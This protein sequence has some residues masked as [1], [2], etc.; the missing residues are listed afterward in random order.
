MKKILLLGSFLVGLVLCQAQ[1]E[2]PQ[3]SVSGTKSMFE[4]GLHA[5]VPFVGGEV[6]PQFGYGGG[7]HIRLPLDHMFAIRLEGLYAMAKGD[8]MNPNRQFDNTWLSGALFGVLTLNNMRFDRPIRKTNIY[9][10]GGAGY[11][12]MEVVYTRNDEPRTPSPRTLKTNNPFVA[13][14]AGIAFR[15]SKRMN[16]G[17]EHQTGFV[18]GANADALDGIVRTGGE[19][20]AFGDSFNYTNLRINFNIGGDSKSEPLYWVNPFEIALADIS[21][22]ANNR[23][24]LAISDSDGDGVIDVLDQEPD[25]GPDAIVD[26]KGRTLDSDRDGVPD[27]QDMEPYYTPRPGERI[28]NQ[29]VVE[30]PIV[31][32]GV[33]ED[34][35]RELIDEAMNRFQAPTTNANAQTSGGGVTMTDLFLPMVHFGSG[36]DVIKYSDYGTLASVARVIKGSPDLRIAI[37]G[38]TDQTGDE[39]TNNELSYNRALAVIDHLVNNHGIARGR[40]VL[41]WKGQGE[42]LVPSTASYMN[43]RVEFRVASP[44]DVEQDPPSFDFNSNGNG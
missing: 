20:T 44:E 8:Q 10:L 33:T 34:R 30:N 37:I 9:V 2:K 23:A 13:F 16:V 17:I 14:G 1:E 21:K 36:S 29:G 15:I 26:T 7:I 27:H 42:A 24:D 6:T 25:T 43:R 18:P 28:N 40:L 22:K 19:R 11:N 35:V 41:M 31:S 39:S 38:H 12:S 4:V 32:G 3:S 5:G